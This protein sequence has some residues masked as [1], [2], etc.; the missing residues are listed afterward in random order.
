MGIHIGVMATGFSLG[1]CGRLSTLRDGDV[2]EGTEPELMDRV[3]YLMGPPP[4]RRSK[5]KPP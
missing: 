2:V 1:L 3:I 5:C 4:R